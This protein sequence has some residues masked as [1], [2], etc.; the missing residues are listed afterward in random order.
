MNDN[1]GATPHWTVADAIKANRTVLGAYRALCAGPLYRSRRK[2]SQ[3]CTATGRHY[4]GHTIAVLQACG[5]VQ[6]QK[7]LS[8][9][10]LWLTAQGQHLRPSLPK[11]G[12]R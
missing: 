5:L 8:G 4:A 1:G 10:Q 3:W 9:D 6:I 7:T 12:A 11:K 2:P